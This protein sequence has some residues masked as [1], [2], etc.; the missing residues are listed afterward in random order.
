MSPGKSTWQCGYGV[1]T[2][3][4]EVFLVVENVD[5]ALPGDHGSRRADEGGFAEIE[6][7]DGAV[8]PQYLASAFHGS[9]RVQGIDAVCSVPAGERAHE[10]LIQDPALGDVEIGI[11]DCISVEILS[12][13]ALQGRQRTPSPVQSK[14]AMI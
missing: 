14:I 12:P 13:R 11:G 3:N 2:W 4:L 10:E 7:V 5:N 8:L 9:E 6:G 1:L